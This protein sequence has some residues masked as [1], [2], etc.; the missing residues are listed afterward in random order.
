MLASD[1][2][3]FRMNL[4]HLLAERFAVRNYKRR[5]GTNMDAAFPRAH[6]AGLDA[7]A[8]HLRSVLGDPTIRFL[9]EETRPNGTSVFR[10]DEGYRVFHV[11]HGRQETRAT[12]GGEVFVR[13]RDGRRLTIEE[14]R[15]ERAAAVPATA[16]VLP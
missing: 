12:R 2:L 6:R 9:Y 11:F 7:E 13:T 5:I 15:A 10:S 14:F 16:P 8:E 4:I 1:D 3:S